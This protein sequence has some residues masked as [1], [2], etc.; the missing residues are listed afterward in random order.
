MSSPP[1]PTTT[2]LAP[3]SDNGVPI[4]R[5][6]SLRRAENVLN[7]RG[8]L[9]AALAPETYFTPSASTSTSTSM[10]A[11]TSMS[12]SSV[13][14]L[15]TSSTS[16]STPSASAPAPSPV[17]SR[18][19]SDSSALRTLASLRRKLKTVSASVSVPRFPGTG[20]GN[21]NS[22]STSI[23]TITETGEPKGRH[24]RA[25]SDVGV[26]GEGVETAG[27][28]GGG[29]EGGGRAGGRGRGTRASLVGS[30]I[31]FSVRN[32]YAAQ[33]SPSQ[34]LG[35]V[36][37]R[38]SL[39]NASTETVRPRI[40]SSSSSPQQ[41]P[42]SS[43]PVSTQGE[44]V[45]VPLSAH[46]PS[47]S[48]SLSP[49][50][51]PSSST[52]TLTTSTMATPQPPPA[53]QKPSMADFTVPQLLQQGT[54]MTKVSAKKQQRVVFRLD[55]DQG[56]I[57][58]ES[59]KHRIIPIETIKEL[60]S[61]SEARYYLSQFNFSSAYESRWLTIIY[62]LEGKYKTWHVIA[63]TREVFGMWDVTLR[64]LL[65]VRRELMSGLGNGDLR[66]QVWERQVW[67]G[68][69]GMGEGGTWG[70]GT[71]GGGEADQRLRFEDVEM[72]CKRLNINPSKDDLLRRFQ[73]ADVSNAG[74]LDFANF[75]RFVKLL[76][77]RPELDRLY[78]KLCARGFSHER[79]QHHSHSGAGVGVGGGAGGKEGEGAVFDFV[80]FER[81]MRVC[82]KSDLSDEELKVVFAKYASA[83]P[84]ST[85]STA[86]APA[87]APVTSTP[88]STTP[89]NASST[90][91]PASASASAPSAAA[92]SSGSTDANATSTNPL[93]APAP[94][95]PTKQTG[96]TNGEAVMNGSA[97]GAGAKNAEKGKAKES[98]SGEKGKGKGKEPEGS[99]RPGPAL[100]AGQVSGAAQT[101][102]SASTA[103]ASASATPSTSTSPVTPSPSTAPTPAP[104]AS[105]QPPTPA[106]APPSPT[107]APPIDVDSLIMSPEGFTSF[108]LSTD[109]AAFVDQ[110]LGVYH[111]MS[112]PL[113]EYY[114]SSSHNT[115][116]VGHQLVGDS[117]I[118]GYIRA[119]LHSCRSV[120]L[121]IYDGDPT[122][123]PVVYHGKTLTSKVSLRDACLAIAKYAFV[124]S[125]YPIIISAEVHCGL[126]QQETMVDIMLEVF[127][128][129][130][131]REPVEG[132]RKIEVLPSPEGLRGKV[133]LKAKNL[134]VAA[135][136][137]A[138]AI[139]MG[140]GAGAGAGAGGTGEAVE[141]EEESTSTE[142]SSSTDGEFVSELKQEFHK[143]RNI[144]T[145]HRNKS[146]TSSPPSQ[147]HAFH[148][149][150]SSASST[151]SQSQ[152]SKH[153]KQSSNGK[154]KPRMS[155]SLLSLLVYTVGVKCRGLNKKEQYAPEHVFSLSEN[156]ANK[157]FKQGSG[158]SD[159][160]KHNRTHL[161][162]VYPKGMRVS[163]SNYEPHRYWSAGCQLVAINW[164]TCDLGYMINHCMFQRNGRSGY[165][166]KPLALRT[167]DKELLA[168][169]TKHFLDITIISA[170]QLP[171]PKDGDGHEIMNKS[172]I[173][174]YVEVSVHVP[175]WTQSPFIPNT[176]TGATTP[177][178]TPA[179]GPTSHASKGA[180][181]E[182]TPPPTTSTSTSSS[183][184]L[185]PGTSTTTTRTSTAAISSTS[186]SGSTKYASVPSTS[187]ARTVTYRTSVVKN[188]G[189]NPVWEEALSLPFDCV[190]DMRELVFVRFAVRQ[191]GADE[192]KEPL[193]VY[194]VSLGSLREGFRH[195]PL[196]D[197]QLSQY[198]FSTLF[199]QIDIR[200][201]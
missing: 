48:S 192:D 177:T 50:P 3:P 144:L 172:I 165:V 184:K 149:R 148:R 106:P 99:V 2:T 89:A 49:P 80:V 46:D 60:R 86:P 37:V 62:V 57:I 171:R 162:R 196:H 32:A 47:S 166:L 114:I 139:G 14:N 112:R 4:H 29:R 111:D 158:M 28:E 147:S 163:S 159:L 150:R 151:S 190:G 176:G 17:P 11:A 189:F 61:G 191:E 183:S 107:P 152:L 193:A 141:V 97:T 71:V 170:Q 119:L 138:G 121:D 160:I 52:T 67:R 104:A 180:T 36:N 199:V 18:S 95:N 73:Q 98:D 109:N 126:Q 161:V 153:S 33:N 92:P 154:E 155:L 135:G 72:L 41:R 10:S 85:A 110:N 187:T 44:P 188:N 65:G 27:R 128:D 87:P 132:R 19:K 35:R 8:R 115:Y 30:I 88:T 120:E 1:P 198:L 200:D 40:A 53:D 103:P 43:V 70:G 182:S 91:S 174:P 42:I 12:S 74:Y 79:H 124:V 125:P 169:R 66:E 185:T 113:S 24:A 181:S 13:P 69:E 145:H 123:G 164:Q 130:L 143:A 173:D 51:P 21:S 34:P 16:T 25:M 20:T 194:G 186:A 94:A 38:R 131:V 157:M 15:E 76:K 96:D 84:N 78:K 7:S 167:T 146:S 64:R 136:A 75:Q 58:W 116:L 90:I 45:S 117:T 156:T 6:H 55:P 22:S 56:Q 39:S 122:T 102:A 118:E 195:L 54:P 201:A 83:P 178:F 108:L 63:P 175:D 168:K 9:N 82:Q 140:A 101:N 93:S 77:T 179:G 81:F 5:S 137:P 105:S 100:G 59:K 197:S 23:G 127:G 142:A 133:M 31:T 26:S 68:A 134:Y 129:S